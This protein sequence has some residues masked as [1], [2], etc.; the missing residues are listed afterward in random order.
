M[1]SDSGTVTLLSAGGTRLDSFVKPGDEVRAPL[2]VRDD[3]VY[4]HSLDEIVTALRV[5]GSGFVR[6]W[7]F[8]VSG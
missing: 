3:I 6:E 5:A 7:D 8:D 2:T 4:V 1:A